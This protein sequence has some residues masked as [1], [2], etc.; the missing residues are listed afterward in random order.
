MAGHEA[1]I[2]D[3]LKALGVRIAPS[4]EAG[5]FAGRIAVLAQDLAAEFPAEA[6]CHET[7]LLVGRQCR[8]WPNL[9]ELCDALEPWMRR[10]R[11][12]RAYALLPAAS[13]QASREPYDP[14]PAPAWCFEGG[15]Q[16][17]VKDRGPVK[18]QFLT[19]GQLNEAYRRAGVKGPVVPG[20]KVVNLRGGEP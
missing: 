16:Q 18:A 17:Q 8:Y 9:A 3:W 2:R 12:S 19:R 14:G 4:M 13:N 1:L 6:F 15:P 20:P 7:L 11:A 5:E 10:W